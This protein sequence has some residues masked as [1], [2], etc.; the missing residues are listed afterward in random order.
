ML[1]QKI[2]R[3]RDVPGVFEKE[4]KEGVL[5][6]HFTSSG[7]YDPGKTWGDPETCYPPEGEDERILSSV[8]YEYDDGCF[9][10]ALPPDIAKILFELY[11]EEIQQVEIEAEQDDD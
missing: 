3:W 9:V 7:Y 5:R 1:R 2:K 11:R 6:I 10:A 8:F 4:L